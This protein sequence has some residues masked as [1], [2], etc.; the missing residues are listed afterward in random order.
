M[1]KSV[2]V[3]HL[4]RSALLDDVPFTLTAGR[5]PDWP[6]LPPPVGYWHRVAG[7]PRRLAREEAA[8]GLH[9]ADH[10]VQFAELKHAQHWHLS[11]TWLNFLKR[12]EFNPSTP[13]PPAVYRHSQFC[14]S[15]GVI[16]MSLE[17]NVII[18]PTTVL[19]FAFKDS[20]PPHMQTHSPPS[21]HRV[22]FNPLQH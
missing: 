10:P 22:S 18:Q 16:E 7:F 1:Y 12:S 8:P 19:P 11:L 17:K 13:A 5:A 6:H 9:R 20:H 15:P 3:W 4:T 2:Q 14:I 21:Q